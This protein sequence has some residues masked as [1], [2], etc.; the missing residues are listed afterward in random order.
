MKT[1]PRE[2]K[3]LIWMESTRGRDASTAQ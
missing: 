3:G 1:N 2:Y